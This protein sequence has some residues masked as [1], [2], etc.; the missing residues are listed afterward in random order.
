MSRDDEPLPPDVQ[1]FFDAER[2]RPPVPAEEVRAVREATETALRGSPPAPGVGRVVAGML[3]GAILGAGAV[4]VLRPARVERVVQRVVETREVPTPVVVDAAVA[5]AV[6][7]DAAI[8][9]DATPTVS[10]GVPHA[11][12]RGGDGLARE[13]LLLQRAR[14]ALLHD[15]GGAALVALQMHARQYPSGAM[16]EE[17]EALLVTALMR[18]RRVGEARAR[19]ADFHRRWPTSLLGDMVDR[20][21][22]SSTD[23]GTRE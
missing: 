10:D 23:A 9:E 7:V 17:R 1:S 22:A 19:A 21:V 12:P 6:P 20:A 4:L 14:S 5:V 15:E 18:V 3:V 8:H 2:A 11:S 16:V 13:Q